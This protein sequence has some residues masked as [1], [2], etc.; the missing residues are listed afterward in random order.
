[1]ARYSMFQ[2]KPALSAVSYFGQLIFKGKRLAKKFPLEE[3]TPKRSGGTFWVGQAWRPKGRLLA[4][5]RCH[6]DT[7]NVVTKVFGSTFMTGSSDGTIAFF[8]AESLGPSRTN[9]P[10]TQKAIRSTLQNG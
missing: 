3:L 10:I 8:S 9:R 4:T 7:V 2:T 6:N 5:L 1:M